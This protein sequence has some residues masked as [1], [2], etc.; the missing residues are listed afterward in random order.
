MPSVLGELIFALEYRGREIDTMYSLE[1]SNKIILPENLF[2]IGTMNTAD[3]S[4]GHIDYALRRRFAFETIFPQ[5]SVISTSEGQNLFMSVANL[6]CK[7]YDEEKKLKNERSI[8]L[9][10]DF[11][12]QDVMIG[13]SYFMGDIE[14]LKMKLEYEIKPILREYLKDGI[15]LEDAKN[16]I[17]N[18]YA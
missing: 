9:S 4:V 13:H 6:F 2:I 15:L 5:K 12:F 7:N 11:L 10:T 3:R 14:K 16:E 17:E 1:D 8:Y 18:L